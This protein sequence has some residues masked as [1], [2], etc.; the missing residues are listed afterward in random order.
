MRGL[1]N[2]L[3]FNNRTF[4]TGP[5]ETTQYQGSG[6][7]SKLRELEVA[8][9]RKRILADD[10]EAVFSILALFSEVL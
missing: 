7:E 8:A 2:R 9:R 10:E 5:K 1:F 3:I 4:N 6:G